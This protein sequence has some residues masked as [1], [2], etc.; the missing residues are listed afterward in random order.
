M[1]GIDRDER[2]EE[3]N[4]R[5][6]EEIAEVHARSYDVEPLLAGEHVLDEIQVA[7]M[8]DVAGR[9]LLH[10]QCHIGTDTLSWARL[11]AVV[12]GVDF[13]P[14]SLREAVKLATRTGLPARFVESSLYDLP[15]RLGETF[16][17]VY[18]SVGVLCWLSDLDAWARIVAAHLKPGGTFYMMESHP[19]LNVFDDEADGLA[20]AHPYFHRREPHLW[21]G[22]HPDYADPDYLVGSGSAEW[23]WSMGDILDALLKAGLAPEFLHEYD[24]I[25]WKALPCMVAGERSGWYRLPAGMDLLPLIFTLRAR[26]P[27][28]S[29][30]GD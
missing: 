28:G 16:D 15:G 1:S 23:T 3:I 2:S 9:T 26:R 30:S 29:S 27:A 25:P 12:T 24:E 18:T 14:A 13:S 22:D 5:H 20:V 17:V 21:P 19:F 10:L 6:W 11:G 7:E 4:L 8:G